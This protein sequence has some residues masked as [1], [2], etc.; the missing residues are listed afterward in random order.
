MNRKNVPILILQSV[1]TAVFT[2]IMLIFPQD[3]EI[4]LAAVIAVIVNLAASVS[5][6]LGVYFALSNGGKYPQKLN[7][8]ALYTSSL[9][10]FMTIPLIFIPLLYEHITDM[11][12]VIYQGITAILLTFGIL[13][14]DRKYKNG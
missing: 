10:L 4:C 12:F 3:S 11:M 2:V 9:M 13:Y 1:I 7:K 5:V 8:I 14:L 6:T